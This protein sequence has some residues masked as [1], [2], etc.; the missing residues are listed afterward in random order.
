MFRARHGKAWFLCSADAVGFEPTNELAPVTDTRNRRHQPDSAKHPFRYSFR[1]APYE[2]PQA[3]LRGSRISSLP[4]PWRDSNPHA[5]CMLIAE[6]MINNTI[7]IRRAADFESAVYSVF[8][9]RGISSSLRHRF[10]RC[11]NDAAW[12]RSL[13]SF[14][15]RRDS[16]PQSIRLRIFSQHYVA[17]A[18]DT[19][20]VAVRTMSSPYAQIST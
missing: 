10:L 14:Y 8:H 3:A 5:R 20:I 2:A 18:D 6:N 1:C 4:Y 11:P 19:V 15:P 13:S 17:I 12:R 9:H 16:N 7:N